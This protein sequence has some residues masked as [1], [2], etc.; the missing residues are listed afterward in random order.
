MGARRVKLGVGRQFGDWR[1]VE[2]GKLGR[3]VWAVESEGGLQGVLKTARA[4]VGRQQSRFEHEVQVMQTLQ[5]LPGVL[6]VLDA[7][8]ASP[9][10][11]MV[12]E[13]AKTFMDHFGSRPNLHAVVKAFAQLG[14]GAGRT[15]SRAC[16]HRLG[17]H[18]RH[19]HR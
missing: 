13:R 12:T 17:E 11:W 3:D 1:L 7:D 2:G 8:S 10:T 14:E 16:R 4:E 15:P 18:R 5:V 19:H 6:R 9:P